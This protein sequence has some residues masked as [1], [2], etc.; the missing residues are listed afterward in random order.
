MVAVMEGYRECNVFIKL[1]LKLAQ[2]CEDNKHCKNKF[3]LINYSG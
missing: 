1:N 2:H 3:I